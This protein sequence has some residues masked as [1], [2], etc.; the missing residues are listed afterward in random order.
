MAELR[1]LAPHP[2]EGTD[3]LADDAGTLVRLDLLKGMVPVAG[4][5]PA[6][7]RF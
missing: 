7:C 2:V 6:L 4:V 5:A 3:R 1:G